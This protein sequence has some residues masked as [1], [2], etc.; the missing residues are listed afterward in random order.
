MLTCLCICLQ[1]RCM[2]DYFSKLIDAAG[3]RNWQNAMAAQGQLI[4]KYLVKLNAKLTMLTNV[5]SS[6]FATLS[7]NSLTCFRQ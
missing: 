4:V 1:L 6:T 7:G 5:L 3:E 2:T